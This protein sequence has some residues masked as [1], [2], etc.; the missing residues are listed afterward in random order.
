MRLCPVRQSSVST[1]WLIL[2]STLLSNGSV[3]LQYYINYTGA[4]QRFPSPIG[5]PSPSNNYYSLVMNGHLLLD[6]IFMD[7]TRRL[8][9]FLSYSEHDDGSSFLLSEFIIVHLF[10][11]GLA[12]SK[13]TISKSIDVSTVHLSVERLSRILS[14][15][16]WIIV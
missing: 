12:L 14:P 3:H 6:F 10:A 4:G 16:F 7:F 5:S 15:L 2:I 8:L 11:V 13:R 1:W 9:S